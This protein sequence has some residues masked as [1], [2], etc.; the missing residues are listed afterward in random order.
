MIFHRGYL[1]ELLWTAACAFL[2]NGVDSFC[3]VRL[4]NS[5]LDKS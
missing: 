1:H 2:P 5:R 4:L 3:K